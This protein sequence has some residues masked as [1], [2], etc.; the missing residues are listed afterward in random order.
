MFPSFIRHACES[1][2]NSSNIW[3][4]GTGFDVTFPTKSEEVSQIIIKEKLEYN[5]RVEVVRNII[6][7]LLLFF[8]LHFR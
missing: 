6:F 2:M 3:L 5:R 1:T 7:S 4:D 8:D